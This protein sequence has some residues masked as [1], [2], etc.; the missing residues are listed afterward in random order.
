M[1][2]AE[3]PRLDAVLPAA[4]EDGLAG[5]E[6][7][8]DLG[9]A[10]LQDAADGLARHAHRRRRLFVAE[11]LEVDEADGLEL[12]DGQRELLEIATGTPAGLNR[13]T[14]GTPP[15]AR[16]MGGRGIGS[17]VGS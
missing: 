6:R 4:D 16:S 7:L 10:A 3:L 12:V 1:R 14:R 9:A 15:T 5:D 2:A 11:A 13:V 8:G 17:S